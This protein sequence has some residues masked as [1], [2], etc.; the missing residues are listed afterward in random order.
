HDGVLEQALLVGHGHPTAAVPASSP[1]AGT[2]AT[3]ASTR[4][5]HMYGNSGATWRHTPFDDVS[6]THSATRLAGASTGVVVAPQLANLPKGPAQSSTTAAAPTPAF[7][8]PCTVAGPAPTA[9]EATGYLTG[10][11]PRLMPLR[12]LR[13]PPLV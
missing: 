8:L 7:R 13:D 5:V 2:Y 3:V 6:S 12:T 1:R 9:P 4:P 10:W 11:H